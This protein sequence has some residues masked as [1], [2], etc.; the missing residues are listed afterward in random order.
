MLE[1]RF[2]ERLREA[3][4]VCVLTGAGV[5]AESGIRT[6][7]GPDGLWRGN[8]PTKLATQEGFETD[9]VLVWEWYRWRQEAISAAEPNAAHRTI[10]EMERHYASFDLVTQ[11]VDGLHTRAGSRRAIELHG[12]IWRMRCPSDGTTIA[13]DAPVREIPPL[14]SCGAVMRPDVVWFGEVLPEEPLEDAVRAASECEVM[15]VV[16]TSSV[17]YPAA[18]L[19]SLARSYGATVIEV[20]PEPTPLS[21]IAHACVRGGAGAVLPEVWAMVVSPKAL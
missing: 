19:P 5:S 4:R 2:L 3:E 20:N 17:V 14:C 9:P 18:Q 12:N 7:R 1:R 6:F 8:D 13:L 21:R 11:N 15:L 10:A 16:G